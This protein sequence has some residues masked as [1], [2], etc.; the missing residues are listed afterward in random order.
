MSET[1]VTAHLFL[2]IFDSALSV[3]QTMPGILHNLVLQERE[4]VIT[5]RKLLQSF[6]HHTGSCLSS[7]A[8]FDWVS[9]QEKLEHILRGT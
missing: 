2:C 8:S 5:T 7:Q 4:K 1:L 3:K 6:S 9:W